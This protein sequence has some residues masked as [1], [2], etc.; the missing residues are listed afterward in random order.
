MRKIKLKSKIL[1]IGILWVNL[2]F[3]SII[4]AQNNAVKDNSSLMQPS[5]TQWNQEFIEGNYAVKIFKLETVGFG[6]QILDKSKTIVCQESMSYFNI[7]LTKIENAKRI[8]IWHINNVKPDENN[9]IK[10][11]ISKA[12]Q[13]GVST[14]E[15]KTTTTNQ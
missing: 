15:L 10:F 6:Y 5:L 2:F 12:I 1:S 9:K 13:F 11:D 14:S 3:V 4:M 8:A 7:P